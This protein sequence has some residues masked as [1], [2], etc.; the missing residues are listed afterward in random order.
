M[1]GIRKDIFSILY[2]FQEGIRC[3]IIV[4]PILFTL[5]ILRPMYH[6]YLKPCKLLNLFQIIVK[7]WST[8]KICKNVFLTLNIKIWFSLL[9][10]GRPV[11]LPAEQRRIWQP[12]YRFQRTKLFYQ[13][14]TILF[15]HRYIAYFINQLTNHLSLTFIFNTGHAKACSIRNCRQY[16]TEK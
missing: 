9:C 8:V 14:N 4:L 5:I 13:F 2:I 7:M 10:K 12:R 1:K 15:S 3:T 6:N 11:F 16:R